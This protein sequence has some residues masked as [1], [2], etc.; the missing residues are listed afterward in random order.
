MRPG[1]PFVG[2]VYARGDGRARLVVGLRR[3]GEWIVRQN[4]GCP[5]PDWQK[6]EF[7]LDAN[8][9]KGDADF[10]IAAEDGT[11]QID[12]ASMGTGY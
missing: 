5:S 6:Y 10:A 11:L 12:Q 9:Y 4:L 3:N 8:G 1:D 2:S 7:T